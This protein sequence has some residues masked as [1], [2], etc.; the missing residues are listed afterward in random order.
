TRETAFVHAIISAGI[1]YTLT[2]NCSLGHLPSCSCD[3]S[4]RV[5]KAVQW[6]WGGCSDNF[7][8]G[9]RMAR[10]FL[11][12]REVNKDINALV[13]L[14]NNRVGRIA[15][16][17]TMRRVCKCHGT[18]GSCASV[19]CW[20]QLAD[21]A[22]VGRRLRQAYEGAR[23][24]EFN[25]NVRPEDLMPQ[26]QA[27][28]N[29]LLYT[30]PSPNFCKLNLTAGSNGTRGRECSLRTGTNVSRSEQ[31]SCR[32]LCNDCGLGVRREIQVH[33]E[34]CNCKFL[35]CCSVKCDT[36]PITVQ[37]HFCT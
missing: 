30:A 3:R 8:F 23:R 14:H 4:K 18:S 27:S 1:T 35:W 28:R 36:C 37:R 10:R 2:K 21:M 7:R 12:T 24:V 26:W 6:T 19:T 31:E 22:E 20:M 17:K 9:D 33:S 15:V 29:V 25:A 16:R 32:K 34:T 13:N 5:A 11:D